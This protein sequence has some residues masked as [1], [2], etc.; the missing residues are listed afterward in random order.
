MASF[1]APAQARRA[2]CTFFL[3]R[4]RRR[5]ARKLGNTSMIPSGVRVRETKAVGARRGADFLGGCG[6]YDGG[7]RPR[8]PRRISWLRPWGQRRMGNGALPGAARTSGFRPGL[9]MPQTKAA[10]YSAGILKAATSRRLVDTALRRGLLLNGGRR[11]E[12]EARCA[13]GW[14]WRGGRRKW[15]TSGGTYFFFF[16][17]MCARCWSAARRFK[18]WERPEDA[19]NSLTLMGSLTHPDNKQGKR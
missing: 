14:R 10:T 5:Y 11:S 1:E 2:S 17:N 18:N 15:N 16:L 3:L 13:V 12:L 6:R 8:P 19:D 7:H 9:Q 4:R